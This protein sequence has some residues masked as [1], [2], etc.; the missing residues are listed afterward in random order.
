LFSS[1]VYEHTVR[2]TG[3]LMADT[4]SGVII[5]LM[6]A[7]AQ[8]FFEL[9]QF[10]HLFWAAPLLIA[11]AIT[12]LVLMLGLPALAGIGVLVLTAPMNVFMAT[13]KKRLRTKHMPIV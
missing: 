7:D 8:K 11:V 6:S 4:S 2:M 12:Y 3:A 13:V 9:S 10:M 5:N 1:L